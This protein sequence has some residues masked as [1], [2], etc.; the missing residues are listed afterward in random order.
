[1]NIL[2]IDTSNNKEIIVEVEIDGKKDSI[3]RKTDAWKAQVVLPMIHELLIKHKLDLKDLHAIS[4]NPG[5][6]SFTGLRVGVAIANTL[7]IWLKIPING[8]SPGKI[9]EPVYQ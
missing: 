7:G 9:V 8:R 6:G 2:L 4:V 3:N 5:P 1:M